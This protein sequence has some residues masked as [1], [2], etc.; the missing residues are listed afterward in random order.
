MD[1]EPSAGIQ[2]R[3][4][5]VR[6]HRVACCRRVTN[7]DRSARTIVDLP[8]ARDRSIQSP[9]RRSAQPRCGGTDRAPAPSR[10]SPS[11]TRRRRSGRAGSPRSDRL[12]SER[13][14]SRPF[15]H[16][17]DVRAS[18]TGP[19]P[20]PTGSVPWVITQVISIPR[21]SPTRLISSASSLDPT[22]LSTFAPRRRGCRSR[23]ASSPRCA[24][25]RG[26][27]PRVVPAG[28]SRG[29]LGADDLVVD[30]RGRPR[31]PRRDS[32]SSRRRSTRSRRSKTRRLKTS[33]TSAVPA[34]DV[35]AREEVF[36]IVS[37][38]P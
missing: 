34:G 8:P 25:W 23:R 33:I 19:T 9:G 16:F 13:F 20:R 2:W 22:R 18:R 27:T 12:Q 29:V 28:R 36:G 30:R 11:P 7:P 6:G 17:E 4:R 21:S 10:E 1:H 15:Q 24:S 26:L 3:P 31:R 14:R 37:P 32:R 35:T 38:P 5:G